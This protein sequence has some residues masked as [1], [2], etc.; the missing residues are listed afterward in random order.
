MLL[1]EKYQTYIQFIEYGQKSN[2][3]INLRIGKKGLPCGSFPLEGRCI[4]HLAGVKAGA[5]MSI[6][7]WFVRECGIT[8]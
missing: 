4:M 7:H 6:S 5:K 2:L 1:E 3:Y 8:T